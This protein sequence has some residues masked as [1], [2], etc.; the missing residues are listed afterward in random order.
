VNERS[1][2]KAAGPAAFKRLAARAMLPGMPYPA[3]LQALL[4]TFAMFPDQA[5]RTNLLL[6]YADRFREVPADIATR[7]F[8][9]EC[10]V[11]H[12]ESEAYVWAIP[13]ADGTLKLAFAVEN[14][15]G[16]SAKALAA[17]LESTL[18]GLPPAEIAKVDPEIVEKIFR[19]NISM[20]KGMGL[21]S[22]VG[23]VRTLAGRFSR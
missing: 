6:S 13:Q 9:Q 3:K 18:S 5:D 17:I 8:P 7:P 14:P 12:C 4:D 1:F 10:L 22:M 21:M 15:A 16:V 11:P 23:A 20:G 19:Q 2:V